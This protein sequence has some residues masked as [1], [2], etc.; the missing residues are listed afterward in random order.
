MY[1]HGNVPLQPFV[2]LSKAWLEGL[3]GGEVRDAC[4]DSRAEPRFYPGARK[5]FFMSQ[6][7]VFFRLLFLSPTYHQHNL[8]GG[9]TYLYTSCLPYICDMHLYMHIHFAY[10]RRATR[11]ADL[12]YLTYLAPYPNP[13]TRV[14]ECSCIGDMC[15]PRTY[16]FDVNGLS[17]FPHASLYLYRL[18]PN[19]KSLP[20]KHKTP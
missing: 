7:G 18:T 11:R 20:T 4:V 12:H 5:P 1:K 13:R 16:D 19:F 14:F 17:G 15:Q 3:D 10:G 6:K 2:N 8:Q 9:L